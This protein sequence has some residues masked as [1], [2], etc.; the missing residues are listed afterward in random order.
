MGHDANGLAPPPLAA[1]PDDL[2][3][4]VGG[5]LLQGRETPARSSADNQQNGISGHKHQL[6]SAALTID[7]SVANG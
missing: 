4:K 7:M 6:G 2:D 1:I 5:F 3:V